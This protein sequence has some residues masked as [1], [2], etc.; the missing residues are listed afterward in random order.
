MIYYRAKWQELI[1]LARIIVT[2][3]LR[4]NLNFVLRIYK[5]WQ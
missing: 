2:C 5:L 1:A 4:G 3:I